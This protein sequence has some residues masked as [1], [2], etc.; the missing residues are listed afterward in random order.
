MMEMD[1]AK[2]S[3]RARLATESLLTQRQRELT[4]A[5]TRIAAHAKA[6]STEVIER[7]EAAERA[8]AAAEN[9]KGENREALKDLRKAR[10]DVQ[11]AERRLWASLETI[12]DGFA[13]FDRD[14]RIVTS[15]A[16]FFGPF[17]DL[18]CVG[19]GASYEDL[20]QIALEEG[21]VD[22]GTMAPTEWLRWMK[23]RWMTRTIEPVTLRLWNDRFVR[24]TER[25]TNDGDIVM[26]ATNMTQTMR[27]EQELDDARHR[28][29]AASRAKSAFLANMS[30][31]IR[32]PMNGVLAMAD[33][34]GDGPLNE[35]QKLCLDTIRS[36]GEAL[37]VIINDVLDYSKIEAAKLSLVEE[38]FDLE[39]AINEVATLLM[40]TAREKDLSLVV[41]YDMFLPTRFLG[42]KGRLRQILMNLAGNAVKFTKTGHVLIRIV[43]LPDQGG[44]GWRLHVTV[45]DTG[46][47]IP[48]EKQDHIFGE[49]NQADDAMTRQFDGTGLGLSITRRLVQMMG[50]EVWVDSTPGEGSVFGFRIVLTP[51]PNAQPDDADL[52]TEGRRLVVSDPDPTS[53]DVLTKQ[54]MALGLRPDRPPNTAGAAVPKP[55]E[56]TD[57][58]VVSEHDGPTGRVRLGIGPDV[59]EPDA[60]GTRILQRPVLRQDLFEALRDVL[61]MPPETPPV[62]RPEPSAPETVV[63]LRHMRVLAAEDNKTNRLV[64]EKLLKSLDIDLDVA[65][66]GAEAV[67]RFRAAPP[68]IVFTDISMP[69]MNG[70]DAARAMR[71][72]IAE[73]GLDAIPIIAMTAHVMEEDKA[74]I[75]AA[76]I[77]AVLTKPLKKD[78]LISAIEDAR[79]KT[80]IPPRGAG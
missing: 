19:I 68:D 7:R 37:L 71:A 18:E 28:A 66:D 80:A 41:D 40:P 79:P 22:P 42:D 49:F 56:T 72:H 59:L 13:V 6:L 55:I 53:R 14:H 43:G 44:S 27:R 76:G 36:S 32:T 74:E 67:D 63:P 57:L 50:G 38:P 30:H 64:L 62:A 31:E 25:R 26:L 39:R 33:I 75:L 48:R 11:I 9:L 10:S 17:E 69:N 23:A 45:E 1:M 78:A 52:P 5:N 70:K 4:V 34:L 35:E 21:I 65:V 24:L 47:G 2:E 51:D 20:V 15:N 73:A 77:D 8:Q 54:L 12:E 60:P 46:V 58:V 3:L 16:S 61:S 29:E